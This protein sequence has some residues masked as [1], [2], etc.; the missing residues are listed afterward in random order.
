MRTGHEG[1]L[2]HQ[3]LSTENDL[4]DKA[5]RRWWKAGPNA[6]CVV[7]LVRTIQTGL[8]ADSCTKNTS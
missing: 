2:L 1:K 4:Q 6:H 5:S 3:S 7:L 8:I